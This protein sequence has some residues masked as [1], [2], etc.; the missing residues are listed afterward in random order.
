MWHMAQFV[1][2]LSVDEALKQLQFIDK[3]GAFIAAE[4]I[5][6][7]RELAV[8]EHCV[9]FGTDLWIA[10]SFATKGMRVKGL[11]RHARGRMAAICYDYMHYH[12]RLEEGRPPKDY[13][14]VYRRPF[15]PHNMLEDWVAEHREKR[16][17]YD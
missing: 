14:S 13:W 17:G 1:R 3:K 10:E 16:A 9:E 11:R 12:V 6:E 5:Q 7:A 15:N 2:G 4:V 8:K